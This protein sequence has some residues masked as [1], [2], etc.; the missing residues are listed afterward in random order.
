M[1]I[2][3]DYINNINNYDDIYGRIGASKERTDSLGN[4]YNSINI[5]KN[6]AICISSH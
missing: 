3:L 1:K 4:K 5:Y 6:I 2:L